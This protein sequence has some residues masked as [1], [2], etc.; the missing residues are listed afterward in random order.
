M[1]CRP[2]CRQAGLPLSYRGMEWSKFQGIEYSSRK[3]LV[4]QICFMC[5]IPSYWDITKWLTNM[6]YYDIL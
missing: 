4:F 1:S 3:M 6:I 2:A 5:L